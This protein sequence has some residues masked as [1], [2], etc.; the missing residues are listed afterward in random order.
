VDASTPSTA[1]RVSA[2]RGRELVHN[3]CQ[4]GQIDLALVADEPGQVQ[5]LERGVGV[6]QLPGG[7]RAELGGRDPQADGLECLGAALVASGL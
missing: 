7:D 6:G 2:Q 1:V 4:P 3:G 5:H